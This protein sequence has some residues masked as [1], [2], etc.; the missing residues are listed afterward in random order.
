MFDTV[1]TFYRPGSVREAVRLLQNGKNRARV[2]AGG[3]GLVVEADRSIRFVVNITL[4]GLS[5]I[6]PKGQA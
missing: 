3:T 4:A 2:V 1:E 5:Y 6:R